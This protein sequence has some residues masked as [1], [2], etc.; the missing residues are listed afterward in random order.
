MNIGETVLASRG[1][2]VIAVQESNPDVPSCA[3][4]RENYVFIRHNDGTVMSYVHLRQ[5]GVD[6][7]QGQVVNAGDVLGQSGNSGCSS[8]PHLHVALFRD[9]TNYDR[10]STLPFNYSNAE[11]E[12]DANNGLKHQGSYL[13]R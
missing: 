9:G 7:T 3:G 10:Q 4:G 6:V 5:N 11:G 12:L 13:A 8:G 2:Q 1:G